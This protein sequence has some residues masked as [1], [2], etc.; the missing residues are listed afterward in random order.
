MILSDLP[1]LKEG[2]RKS[3]LSVYYS[4]WNLLDHAY[5]NA[6]GECVLVEGF[7]PECTVAFLFTLC[8]GDC[9]ETLDNLL[10]PQP[11]ACSSS[12]GLLA[13]SADDPQPALWS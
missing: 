2:P 8:E 3:I 6:P 9:P 5:V 11:Q 12:L 13:L 10:L 7:I 1:G 4:T